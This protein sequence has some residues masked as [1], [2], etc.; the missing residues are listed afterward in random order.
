MG[1]GSGCVGSILI[2][3]VTPSPALGDGA[4]D[5]PAARMDVDVLDPHQ[6]LALA[7][8]AVESVGE[9]REQAHQLVGVLQAQLAA[10]EGL[11][12]HTPGER[13]ASFPGLLSAPGSLL[14]QG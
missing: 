6:L 12:S 13:A 8:V 2:F 7:A 14:L 5:R 11:L 1:D 10:G 3:L 4:D 9:R